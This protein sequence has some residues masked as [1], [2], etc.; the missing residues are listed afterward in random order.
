MNKTTSKI[1]FNAQLLVTEM[2]KRG[3][4]VKNL[5]HTS[6]LIAEYKDHKEFIDDIDLG[7]MPA[8]LRFIL[9]N[10]W[11]TKQLLKSLKIPVAEGQIF[12]LNELDKAKKYAA[13]HLPVVIKPIKG[14][15][16]YGV[17]PSI[18]TMS[19]FEREFNNLKKFLDQ[20][21]DIIV[22]EHFDGADFRLSATKNGFFAATY[23]TFP[24]VIG[25]SKHTI[26]ELILLE[27]HRRMHPRKNSLCEIWLGDGE[28]DRYL[29]KKNLNINYIPKKTEQIYLRANANVCT[30]GES[31]DV[32]DLVHPFYKNLT[33]EILKKIPGLPYCGIDLITKDISQHSK[34]TKYIICEINPSP[35]ISLHTHPSTGIVRRFDKA[36]VDLIFPETSTSQ[37]ATK[38]LKKPKF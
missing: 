8:S 19:E 30:G 27:N 5:E 2:G 36:L 15:H 21:I 28:I 16:G 1:H 32:T 13:K 4:K 37:K 38:W 6:T 7:I 17:R 24:K 11:S 26:E 31:I 25:D 35:G 3:I 23:R 14:A 18:D 33:F 12:S 29:S 20:P 22:E 34:N 10:K 9:D